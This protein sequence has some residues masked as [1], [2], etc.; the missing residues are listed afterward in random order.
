M[1]IAPSAAPVPHGRW[2]RRRSGTRRTRRAWPSCWRRFGAGGAAPK[3]RPGR[4]P[5]MLPSAPVS[6]AAPLA[7]VIVLNW[8]GEALITECV[9]S[10]LAQT[11]LR[12]EILVVDNASTDRSVS[13]IRE[14]YGEKVRL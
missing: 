2:R 6:A 14:R 8:N 1:R 4:R 9:D 10:L 12:L 5:G 13:L 7:S 11:D 3:D